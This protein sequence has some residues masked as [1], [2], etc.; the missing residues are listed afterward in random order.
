MTNTKKDVE[1]FS[2]QLSER[3]WGHRFKDGQ[4]GEEYLLEFLNVMWGTKYK[5]DASYYERKQMIG[6][7]QFV[8]EGMKEGS[9]SEAPVKLDPEKKERLLATIKDDE[10]I[11]IIRNFLVNLEVPLYDKKGKEANRSWYA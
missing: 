9:K 7:R 1:A 5:L 4:K 6:F 8:F 3:I 2:S 11:S 10:R